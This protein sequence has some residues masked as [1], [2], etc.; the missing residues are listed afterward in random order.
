MGF[1]RAMVESIAEELPIDRDR[2]YATGHSAGGAFSHRLACEAADLI[3]AAVPVSFSLHTTLIGC[4]PSR[5]IAVLQFHGLSDP[6]V[7][8]A[9]VPRWIGGPILGAPESAASWAGSNGCSAL[10]ERIT[11]GAD[12]YRDV[13]GGCDR[14]VEVGLSPLAGCH[15]LYQNNSDGVL[16]RDHA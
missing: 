1:I 4:E 8:Y 9:G 6:S 13:Y 10:P 16:I 14:D 7:P 2:I 15:F 12:S 11:L 5:P 3:A